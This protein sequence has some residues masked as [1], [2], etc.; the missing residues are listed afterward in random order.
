MFAMGGLRKQLPVTFWTFLIAS[1]SLAALP[2][3]TAGFYSKDMILW[4]AWS[5]QAGS[6][7]LWAAGLAG[8]LLTSIYAF[9]MVFLTFYG[10]SKTQVRRK[11]GLRM[12]LPLVIL[13]VLS[14]VGGFVELPSFLGNL[15]LFSDFLQSALPA[16]PSMRGGVSTEIVLQCSAAAVSLIGIYLAYR[17][18]L[19]TPQYAESLLRTTWGTALHRVW[20]AGWGFDWLYDTFLVGPYVWFAHADKDD[21]VDLIYGGIAGLIQRLNRLLSGTETGKVR[22]YATGIAIGAV[23]IIAIAVIL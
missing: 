15:P 9:R 2:L 23:I 12:Q 6:P 11:P 16:A 4:E 13:A 22:W 14:V 3:V 20:F 10:P 21:V 19:R 1:A 7:W 5:S 17:L 18:Y 8:A